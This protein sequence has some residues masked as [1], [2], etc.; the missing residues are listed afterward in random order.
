VSGFFAIAFSRFLRPYVIDWAIAGPKRKF[1]AQYRQEQIDRL[2]GGADVDAAVEAALDAAEAACE[3]F[4]H[5]HPDEARV[6]LAG[7]ASAEARAGWNARYRAVEVA[8]YNHALTEARKGSA[9][10]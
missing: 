2:V 9:S 4:C 8:A 7:K 10:E 1:K 3:K 6:I 5:E